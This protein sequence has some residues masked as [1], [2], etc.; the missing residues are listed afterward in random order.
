VDL[1]AVG[2]FG[3]NGFSLVVTEELDDELGRTIGM[4]SVFVKISFI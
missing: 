1:I 4:S 2:V 3:D